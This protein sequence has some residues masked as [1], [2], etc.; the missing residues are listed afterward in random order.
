MEFYDR[1]ATFVLEHVTDGIHALFVSIDIGGF[2][3]ALESREDFARLPER[4]QFA[5]IDAR[6]T[7]LDTLHTLSGDGSLT[8]NP[9][10]QAQVYWAEMGG[11]KRVAL[12]CARA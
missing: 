5:L 10:T 8:T 3:I 6:N 12:D 4:E 11:N 9:P 7:L 2:E 1:K